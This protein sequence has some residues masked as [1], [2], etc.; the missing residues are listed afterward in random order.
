MKI[1]YFYIRL[2]GIFFLFSGC[3]SMLDEDVYSQLDPDALFTSANGVERVL[4]GAYRDIQMNDNFG[5]NIAS[6]EEW[7]SD[8]FWETGGAANLQAVVMLGYTWDAAYP[9]QYTNLWNNFYSSIR[10]CNL[11]LENIDN[12]PL[13]DHVKERLAA[14]ARFVRAAG[15]YMLFT[16]YGGVPLRTSTL[17]D[18][19]LAKSTADE[20]SSF[21]ETE[22]LASAELLPKTISEI[23]G[24]EYGRATKGAA[25]A[26]LVKLYL[27]TK[28]WQ[29]CVDA[30]QKVMDLGI[31]ELWPDYTTL[32]AVENEQK[33]NEFIWVSTCSPMGPGNV[34]MS[35]WFPN[36]FAS[37]ADGKITYVVN[38]VNWAR[39]DRIRDSFYD[40]FDPEDDRRKVI[41]SEYINTGGNV[42]SLLNN[43]NTRSFKYVPDPNASGGAHGNDVPIIRYADILLSRAEALNELN[44]PTQEAVDLINQVR[45]RA[46][47]SDIQ[48]GDYTKE[49]LRDHILDERGWEFFQENQR[50]DDLIRHGKLIERAKARGV[51]N[52]ADHHVLFPIPQEEINSNTLCKQNPG[53]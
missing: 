44:G 45:S 37:T 1:K 33:N 31:Y 21:M 52:A 35:G 51:T 32:F 42:V 14:E 43:D 27:N 18:P 25:L 5:N 29:K 30:A 20:I 22:F 53:Y 10:N 40:S 16:R 3:E 24:Y 39:M 19:E 46:N 17:G 26:Y 2:L 47:L 8:H 4:F 50:R 12:S 36:Q 34:S 28:Q 11:V 23:S 48:A 9:V 38:M 13:E 15:Y 49:A 6:Y 7:M 41:V